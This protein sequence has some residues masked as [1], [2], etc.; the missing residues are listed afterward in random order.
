MSQVKTEQVKALFE[1]I[2]HGDSNVVRSLLHPKFEF[3]AAIGTVEQRVYLGSDG[4]WAFVQDMNATWDG[5]RVEL[6]RVDEFGE[7]VVALMR[8]TGTA[9]GS[10][11]PLDQ[12]LGHVITWKDGTVSRMV[13]YTSP[14]EA[15]QAVRVEE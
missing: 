4:M 13:A 2:R 1:A 9:R 3:H 15:L 12:R 6:E 8:A 5:Y 11:I 14:T 7:R 10:G